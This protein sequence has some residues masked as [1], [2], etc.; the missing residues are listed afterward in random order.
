MVMLLQKTDFYPNSWG[1]TEKE[2]LNS[3]RYLFYHK[4]T[5]TFCHLWN[6]YKWILGMHEIWI[7]EYRLCASCECYF[8]NEETIR[9]RTICEILKYAEKWK[10][11]ILHNSIIMRIENKPGQERVIRIRKTKKEYQK[12]WPALL[13]NIFCFNLR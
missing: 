1:E 5:Y 9:V 11:Y 10:A 2:G 13:K 8:L 4:T 3:Y 12:S 7:D 6:I